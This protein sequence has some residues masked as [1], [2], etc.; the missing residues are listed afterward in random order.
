LYTFLILLKQ[1]NAGHYYWE[2]N[3]ESLVCRNRNRYCVVCQ[4]ASNRNE[5][6]SKHECFLNW[7]KASTAMEADGVVEGFL[8]SIEMHGLKYNKLIGIYIIIN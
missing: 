4:R 6:A 1:Y 8:R 2:K 3:Q 7:S 5:K